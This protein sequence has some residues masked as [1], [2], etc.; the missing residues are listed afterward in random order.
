MF[1]LAIVAFLIRGYIRIRIHQKVQVEDYILLFTVV[2]LCADTGLAYAT[3]PGW[4]DL[5]QLVL[6]G[7]EN[8]LA[9]EVL[10]VEVLEEI[11]RVSNQENATQ[12]ISW[13]VVFSV[14]IA[15][16]FFFRRLVSHLRGLNAWWRVATTLTIL[17]GF[18]SIAVSWLTCPYFTIED[19]LCEQRE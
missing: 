1:G 9:F 19:L 12:N 7:S 18:V 14:K 5:I 15:S 16:L 4:Y 3:L 10:E 17:A 13:L 2:C 8:D 6:H 11:P